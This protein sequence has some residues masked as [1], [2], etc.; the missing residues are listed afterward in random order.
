MERCE[1][2]LVFVKNAGQRGHGAWGRP[3]I[4]EL[5]MSMRDCSTTI[6]HAI[7]SLFKFYGLRS[8]HCPSSTVIIILH[9]HR[10]TF[11]VVEQMSGVQQM[12]EKSWFSD[13]KRCSQRNERAKCRGK[14]KRRPLSSQVTFW[15]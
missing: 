11:R 10:M 1:V 15:S 8:I 9:A 12:C 13:G 6:R 2:W 14:A 7:P 3:A 5:R 4:E